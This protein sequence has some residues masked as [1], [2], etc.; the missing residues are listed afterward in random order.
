M[1]SYGV[2]VMLKE[3]GF[4]LTGKMCCRSFEHRRQACCHD[5]P[6]AARNRDNLP[7]KNQNLAEVVGGAMLSLL[8]SASRK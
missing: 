2:M 4:D 8:L 6:A 7:L 3:I 1:H 5:V